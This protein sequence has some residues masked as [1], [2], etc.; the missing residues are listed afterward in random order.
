MTLLDT[1]CVTGV[2]KMVDA[3]V[4]DAGVNQLG[5]TVARFFELGLVV[6]LAQQAAGVDYRQFAAKK[7]T[8]FRFKNQPVVQCRNQIKTVALP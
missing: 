4:A 7:Q 8:F 5:T 3:P 6:P 1:G 2:V